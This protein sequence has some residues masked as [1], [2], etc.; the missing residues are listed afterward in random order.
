MPSFD[1]NAEAELF[2]LTRGK[3]T[4]MR[5]KFTK[6]PVG[7]KRF[8]SAAEAIRFAVEE[9]PPDLLRGAYLEVDEERF[10]ANGIRQLYES[11]TYP[12]GRRA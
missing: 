3:F 10:D 1:Y 12:L 6:R 5:G 11:G 4:K 7:Y 8:T 2:P 9:L